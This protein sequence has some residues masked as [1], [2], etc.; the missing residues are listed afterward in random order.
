MKKPAALCIILLAAGLSFGQESNATDFLMNLNAAINQFDFSNRN[1]GSGILFMP[2]LYINRRHQ[3][4]ASFGFI[5][6]RVNE[7]NQSKEENM[8]NTLINAAFFLRY[9]KTNIIFFL[10]YYRD[11]SWGLSVKLKF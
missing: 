6:P 8:P 1:I 2:S 4:Y 7:N 9:K 11:D 5:L 3:V 10:E